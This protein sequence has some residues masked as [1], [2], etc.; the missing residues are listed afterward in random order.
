MKITEK[1]FAALTLGCLALSTSLAQTPPGLAYDPAPIKEDLTRYILDQMDRNHVKGLSL[2]L[3]DGSNLVW[4]KG[5]GFADE[6]KKIPA[7]GDTLYM[8]GGL[9]KIVTAAEVMKLVERKIIHLDAPIEAY[10]P[11]FSIRSRF[12]PTAKITVKSLL[13]HHSGLPAFYLKGMLSQQP[14]SLAQLVEGLKE[15]SQVEV[16]QTRF[17][18]SYLDYDLLG[19]AL[20]LTRDGSFP[21]VMKR[22][23]LTPLG[24]DSSDFEVSPALE[25]KLAQG[26]YKGKAVPLSRMRDVPVSGMA[27]TANDM[28]KFLSAS[29]TGQAAGGERWLK[30]KSAASM[31]IPPYPAVPEDFGQEV[32]LGWMLGGWDLPGEE[33]VAWHEGSLSPYCSEMAA[34]YRQGLG[35][36]LLS[37]SSEGKKIAKDITLRALKLMVR[38]KTGLKVKLDPPP[39]PA[40]QE[41]K[42]E[43]ESLE[44][45]V[46]LYSALGQATPI[47][48]H[49]R[50]LSMRFFNAGISLLPVGGISSCHGSNFYYFSIMIFPSFP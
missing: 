14:M 47:E 30:E 12:D 2:A 39:K 18:Y 38:A 37:N 3:V 4:S 10:V 21:E 46:G 8:A 13:A 48:R 1:C 11:D 27:S 31:F 25:Q 49:G 34:L 16:P 36:V 32:G 9:S 50:R 45:F 17:R 6:K 44:P 5:F 28:A 40:Y 29:L 19:R 15:D 20:E 41:I 7:T 33:K 43:P 42:V 35:V 23:L 26:F 22:D 24:M